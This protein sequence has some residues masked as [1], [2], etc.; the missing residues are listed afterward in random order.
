MPV[1]YRIDVA[2]KIIRTTCGSP[3]TLEDVIGHFRTLGTDPDC[4]GRLDVFLDVSEVDRVPESSQ[5]A[6]MKAEIAVLRGKVQFGACAIFATR[7]AMFGMMRVFEVVTQPYFA[8]PRVFRDKL[9]AEAWLV[10]R[11]PATNPER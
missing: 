1:T 6:A 2:A 9:E 5:F 8:A 10:S 3:L 4:S 11:N 7:D